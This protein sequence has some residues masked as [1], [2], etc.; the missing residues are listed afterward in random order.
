MVLAIVPGCVLSST[1]SSSPPGSSPSGSSALSAAPSATPSVAGSLVIVGR[2]ITMDEPP[3]AEALLIE[4]GLVTAV[5]SRE[6]VQ[7]LAGNEVPVVD[8]G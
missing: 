3:V 6:E 1:S 2:I 5:G 4:D 8:I 7:A